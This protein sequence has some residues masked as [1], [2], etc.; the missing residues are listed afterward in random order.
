MKLASLPR[1]VVK[2]VPYLG[3]ELRAIVSDHSP[4]FIA[5]PRT[6]HI[7]RDAPCNARCIMCTYGYL[8]GEAYKAISRSDFTDEMM[9]RA[10]SEIHELCGRGTL[11]SYMGG[12]PTVCRSITEWIEQAGRLG[13][14]F[15]FTTNGYI[16]T[17][18]M[19]QRFVAAGLFNIGVSLE[20]LDP[21]INEII[22]PH[23][24]G[25]AKTLRCIELLL[26]ERERQ[27]RHISINIKTV[28][29]SVNMESFLDIVKRY[30]KLDG[31][32][33]TPQIFEPLRDMPAETR[34]KLFIKDAARMQRLTDQI[35]ALKQEGYAI[36]ATEQSLNDLVKVC[37][38]A[39][40]DT[41]IMGTEKLEMD[42]SEP[43]CNIGTDNLWIHNGMVKLCPNHPQIGNMV[44]GPNTT[45]KQM[46]EGEMTRKI[47]AGTRA[48][49]QL[50]TISCLRR[51]PLSHKVSTFLKIA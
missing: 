36:H 11:I 17:Q 21:E 48:C 43:P 39:K 1:K 12:E 8:K 33:C 45:L 26:K 32:M 10:L 29:T 37:Q 28:L 3:K 38:S 50:C 16:M 25:T 24:G 9:P 42:P 30:G 6:V 27:K 5:V 47:R 35:R 19:A 31:V 46:W 15:R 41:F 22:R 2:G 13:L 4:L 14:D 7:W 40:D 51:T 44:T 23:D 49:R 18:E 20:S 34:Q